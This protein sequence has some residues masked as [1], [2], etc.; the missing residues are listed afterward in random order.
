MFFCPSRST[1]T[2]NG[3]SSLLL[4]GKEQRK[5]SSLISDQYGILVRVLQDI[6]YPS[7]PPPPCPLPHPS[8]KHPHSETP[9]TRSFSNQPSLV[10]EA[11]KKARGLQDLPNQT[12]NPLSEHF[13]C[14]NDQSFATLQQH[15]KKTSPRS[16][17]RVPQ[18]R[19]RPPQQ[20]ERRQRLCQD[21][22]FAYAFRYDDCVV[23]ARTPD[24]M[25]CPAHG[26]ILLQYMA[27]DTVSP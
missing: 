9:L 24:S 8:H 14:T 26:S 3:K 18:T 16:G 19:G 20:K 7:F 4:D 10:P 13:G 23:M 21:P 6:T 11:E 15:K 25:F 2:A 27:P 5:S 22:Q 1:S 17:R 12:Q